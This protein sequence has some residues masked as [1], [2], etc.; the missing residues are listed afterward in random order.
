[1]EHMFVYASAGASAFA[2]QAQL[3]SGA[4]FSIVAKGFAQAL[5][6]HTFVLSTSARPT[7]L[8]EW[9]A[10]AGAAVLWRRGE[11]KLPLQVGLLLLVAWGLDGMFTLRGL[12]L[13]YFV[14]TDPL[15]IL[16]G[17][18]VLGHL[19]DLQTRPWAQKLG[20]GLLALYVVWAHIE[21]VKKT[22]TRGEREQSCAWFPG[23][24]KQVER[25][26]F[27]KT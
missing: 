8:V 16:A 13:A 23:L 10:I 14:Y 3:V 24:I 26:P 18:L 6:M 11:R 15:L 22:I 19:P 5:A 27:C 7:L 20:L 9:F 17:V 4:L 12:Q 2:G 25:F 21:P 1:V